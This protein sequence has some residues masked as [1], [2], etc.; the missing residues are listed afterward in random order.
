MDWAKAK[1]IL[2]FA[3][4]ITNLLL[5]Y[6]VLSALD[7][8]NYVH[9]I[10][11]ERIDGVKK[12]LKE[13]NIM[14][15]TE[16]PQK[17]FNLPELTLE[18][19]T[20]DSNEIEK[21]FPQ[22]IIDDKDNK[23]YYKE[24]EMV[25]I[26]FHRK[27]IKYTKDVKTSEVKYIDKE[28]AEKIAYDF[29]KSHGFYNNEAEIWN[30]T[31]KEG[32][33]N[34]EYKQKYKDMI[35]DDGYMKITVENGEVVRFERRWLNITAN[36]ASQKNVIPATK[37]LLLAIGDLKEKKGTED[38]E[39]TI[40]DINLVYIIKLEE[41]LLEDFLDEEWYEASENTGFLYWRVRLE[42]KGD[43]DIQAKAY[44]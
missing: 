42:N 27:S 38:S 10:N 23:K 14:V 36:K 40:T 44:E 24:N 18:Y 3:F 28:E 41:P 34:L 2:I 15:K 32:K 37:A 17:V 13:K 20:Y 12:I 19:E 22:F 8:R 39:I 9:S 7:N 33:Y 30:I 5:G 6:N 16:I 11:E 31:G 25:E 43:I 4:I 21:K 29:I 35:L 1:N 26:P